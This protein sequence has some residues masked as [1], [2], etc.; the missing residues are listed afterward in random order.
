MTK[1]MDMRWGRHKREK[2]GKERKEHLVYRKQLETSS[3]L[4]FDVKKDN[5]EV[6]FSFLSVTFAI[7]ATSLRLFL[8][9][10]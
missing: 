1:T 4:L 9:T 6:S 3:H 10:V 5:L 2:V 7:I 8:S